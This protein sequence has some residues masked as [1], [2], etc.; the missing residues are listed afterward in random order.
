MRQRSFL[1]W[2]DVLRAKI[3]EPGVEDCFAARLAL[4]GTGDSER[5]FLNKEAYFISH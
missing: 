4:R 5:E 1:N 2:C 3:D